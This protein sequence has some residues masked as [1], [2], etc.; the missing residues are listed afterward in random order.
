M[1]VLSRTIRQNVFNSLLDY[2]SQPALMLI[3][4]PLLLRALG[5]QQ[6]DT[7]MLVNSIAATASGLG[8]GFGDGATK[9]VYKY[10]GC[11]DSTGALRS[12]MAVLA[13]NCGFGLLAAIVMAATGIRQNYCGRYI[14]VGIR[15]CWACV[16]RR[17]AERPH[18]RCS[19][20]NRPRFRAVVSQAW[21]LVAKQF[22]Q[23]FES[24]TL[25]QLTKKSQ[26]R[27]A[28]LTTRKFRKSIV[29]AFT[30]LP[31]TLYLPQR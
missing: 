25:S 22:L 17:R 5:V 20:S 18:F 30:M 6:Y 7:W 4:A 8:G 29:T 23:S 9:Y 27:D 26:L 31:V 3:G 1:T 16:E 19:N 13:L 11:R 15:Y 10:R 14:P 28:R 24:A 12:T 2:V 21:D